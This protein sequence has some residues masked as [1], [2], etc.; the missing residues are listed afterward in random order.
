MKSLL[1]FLFPKWQQ[2]YSSIKHCSFLLTKSSVIFN[3]L[4]L[5][6]AKLYHSNLYFIYIPDL[7]SVLLLL[8]LKCFLFKKNIKLIFLCFYCVDIKKIKII[9]KKIILIFFQLKNTFVKVLC[10]VFT[11]TL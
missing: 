2:S 10:T 3:F 8:F 7:K 9:K 6:L 11:N 5:L 4:I 1:V